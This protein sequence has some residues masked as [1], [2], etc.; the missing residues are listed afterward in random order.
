MT[1]DP[2][3]R[4]E[5][6]NSDGDLFSRAVTL[7]KYGL[8]AGIS[9]LVDYG[10]FILLLHVGWSIM[11]STYTAR[12]CS[13]IVNF[14]LN[15]NG[16]FRSSGNYARQL[17]H[18]LLLVVAAATVSGLAVTVLT[19]HFPIP[20]PLAKFCVEVVLF[21]INYLIQKKFIFR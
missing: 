13:C 2:A 21:F 4:T 19:G 12:A 1:Q 18:Y 16:V 17:I 11:I 5:E 10:L 9:F 20:A 7:L 8:S 3:K 6:K 15:R 14:I